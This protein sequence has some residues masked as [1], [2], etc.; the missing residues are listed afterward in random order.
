MEVSV[1]LSQIVLHGITILMSPQIYTMCVRVIKMRVTK[2][3]Q[4]IFHAHV[5][6]TSV[7]ISASLL[8]CGRGK[9]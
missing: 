2:T 3:T 4:I 5:D 7:G 8:G 1:K 6:L 9:E